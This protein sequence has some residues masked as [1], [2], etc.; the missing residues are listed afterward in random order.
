MRAAW[1][2]GKAHS[3]PTVRQ[4]ADNLWKILK[5]GGVSPTGRGDPAEL[6]ADVRTYLG[7]APKYDER[8]AAL[9]RDMIWSVKT[10]K[11]YQRTGR[12]LIEVFDGSR[13]AKT[14]RKAIDDDGWADLSRK[15]RILA[16]AGLIAPQRLAGLAAIEDV[17]RSMS[18]EPFE[19]DHDGIVAFK[20][21]ALSPK[22]WDQIKRGAKLLED[23]RRFPTLASLLPARPIGPIETSWRTRLE[24]P[25]RLLVEISGW[26]EAATTIWPEGCET[27]EVREA[28]A[29]RH[30]PG[31]VGIFQAGLRRYVDAVG[32]RRGIAA[33]ETLGDLF[34]EIDI[35]GVARFWEQ[36]SARPGGLSKRTMFQYMS[37]IGLALARVG[38][39][40]KAAIVRRAIRNV[41]TL[42]EGRLASR[43]MSPKSE[44]WCSA[45]LADEARIR[46]FELLHKLCRDRAQA[47]LDEAEAR[48]IDLVAAAKDPDVLRR[49]KSAKRK[50]AR[51]LLKRARK[52]GV[53]A[54][55]AAIE[56]E[57]APF[58]E[59]NTLGLMKSGAGQTFFDHSKGADPHF[60]IVIPN[61][62]LKNGRQMTERGEELPPVHIRRRGT[63]DAG[64]EILNFYLERIRPLFPRAALC[65]ALFPSL[66]ADSPHLQ[67]NTFSNWLLDASIECGLPMTS[68]NFRHGRCSI[69]INDDPNCIE[70]LAVLPR[71]RSRDGETVLRVSGQEPDH[72]RPAGPRRGTPEPR[73]LMSRRALLSKPHWSGF[74]HLPGVGS[75]PTAA[76]T[77][78]DDFFIFVAERGLADPQP[79]DISLWADAAPLGERGELLDDLAA[80][81]R[82]CIPAFVARV[83]EARALPPPPVIPAPAP[84]HAPRPEAT[85]A[86]AWDPIAPP[87]RKP[88]RGALGV[89]RADLPAGGVARGAPPHGARNARQRR[90]R[91]AFHPH[92]DAGKALPVRLVG[93]Q[94]RAAA[95]ADGD[96]HRLLSGRPDEA[97]RER[98]GRTEMGDAP[99]L[100]GRASPVRQIHRRGSR[101][102]R[103]SR[104]EVRAAR[105]ARAAPEG[106]EVFPSG[107]DRQH[108]LR[109]ARPGGRAARRLRFAGLPEE[110]AS[111][112]QRRLHPGP[113]SDRAA[114][115]G[116]AGLRFG[117][118]L[119]WRDGAWVIDTWIRKTRASN[120]DRFVMRLRPQHGRFI[121]AVLLGDHD[122]AHLPLLRD[123]A[124]A[125]KRPLFVLPDG[126]PA[127]VTYVPR[128]YKALT[129]NSFGTTRTMLHTDLATDLGVAGRDMAMTAC[130]QTSEKIARK[131]QA[132]AVAIAAF[133]RRQAAASARRARYADDPTADDLSTRTKM[134]AR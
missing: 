12:C 19:L 106:A 39:A 88:P 48:E 35:Y 14:A 123:A 125:A 28:H 83:E 31:S 101:G 75:L 108:H 107:A 134:R 1:E 20:E 128:I 120:P 9:N 85:P 86:K 13:A 25:E 109:R 131:Y 100:D 6:P 110:T 130:H 15:A 4:Y 22:Q 67:A 82:V 126:H 119:D 18:T 99:G 57:G 97:R 118:T 32:R 95:R 117:D 52:F 72:G 50:I 44:T 43:R 30:A 73:R 54:A 56:L 38:H 5:W 105:R 27:P 24:I 94:P 53:V 49:M 104:Q 58:R 17:S 62:L 46:A 74:L 65:G 36:G 78:A 34:G 47:A 70:E 89:G 112:P 11:Q 21:H 115:P 91:L 77:A 81:M 51:R 3:D 61:E 80:A 64:V 127:A 124:I 40:D 116:S 76:L 69:E 60:R 16:D 87:S 23:F 37:R 33:T 26:V 84:K 41:P 129:G 98:T 66:E 63:A 10:Y 7:F 111:A 92:A 45:L 96:R 103:A 8:N 71:R 59:E 133:S 93:R 42:N 79:P 68:H 121:D 114:P 122:P 132:E 102:A 2:Y 90:R 55:F 29:T 113:L